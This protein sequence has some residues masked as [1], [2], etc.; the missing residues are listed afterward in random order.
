MICL[1][2]ASCYLLV[3]IKVILTQQGWL[4]F[5]A[6]T[7]GGSFDQAAFS[8]VLFGLFIVMFLVFEPYGLYGLWLRTRNYWKGWPFSY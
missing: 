2:A 1:R 7:G 4:P 8:T 5:V 6:E 3:A